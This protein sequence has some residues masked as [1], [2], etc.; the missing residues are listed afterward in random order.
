MIRA[1]AC[2]EGRENREEEAAVLIDAHGEFQCAR[3]SVAWKV[4]EY[5]AP[6]RCPLQCGRGVVDA[7]ESGR[8]ALE[9]IDDTA[10]A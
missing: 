7:F 5:T 9:V 6:V 8:A 3:A 1:G 4:R 10:P 2:G